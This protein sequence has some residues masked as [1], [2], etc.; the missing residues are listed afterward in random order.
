MPSC[1]TRALAADFA[2][3]VDAEVVRDRLGQP[4]REFAGCVAVEFEA[5]LDLF[6]RRSG[7]AQPET[8]D[9]VADRACFARRGMQ[10]RQC[11]QQCASGGDRTAWPGW[12]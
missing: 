10:R 9:G 5:N 8:F 11:E 6:F 2:A 7:R 3:G 12:K 4:Q 1:S